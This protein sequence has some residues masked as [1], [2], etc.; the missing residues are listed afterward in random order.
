M[1]VNNNPVS[2]STV[3]KTKS[4]KTAVPKSI[5]NSSTKNIQNS[6]TKNITPPFCPG[7][8]K[9][10]RNRTKYH[11]AKI[12]KPEEETA[13]VARTRSEP[14]GMKFV[15]QNPQSAGKKPPRH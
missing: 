1:L 15:P 4:S 14:T 11:R 12:T 6:S 8:N 2:T 5:Q 10:K 7:G 3:P 13:S 9:R